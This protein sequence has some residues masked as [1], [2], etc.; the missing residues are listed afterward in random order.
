MVQIPTWDD[1]QQWAWGE[2]D[3]EEESGDVEMSGSNSYSPPQGNFGDDEEG[4]I[5]KAA[6][7]AG[8][9]M[10][11]SQALIAFTK[12]YKATH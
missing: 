9:D 10:N 1:L 8:I 6:S 12:E 4:Q 5:L 11:D 2:G 7:K 3:W